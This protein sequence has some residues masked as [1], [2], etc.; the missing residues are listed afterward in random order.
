MTRSPH[1]KRKGFRQA[2]SGS[3]SLVGFKGSRIVTVVPLPS[4]LAIDTVPPCASTIER[5]MA[6]PSPVPPEPL[7]REASTRQV[8]G[9]DALALVDAL[10]ANGVLLGGSSDRHRLVFRR[11][12]D[13][14]TQQVAERSYEQLRVHIGREIFRDLQR[15]GDSLTGRCSLDCVFRQ[16]ANPLRGAAQCKPALVPTRQCRLEKRRLFSPGTG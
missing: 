6:R 12:A 11:M 13:C 2:G 1:S 9:G 16:L 14:V 15:D 3:G 7:S 5:T 8:L 10:D 4:V